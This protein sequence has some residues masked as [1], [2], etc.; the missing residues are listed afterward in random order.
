MTHSLLSVAVKSKILDRHLAKD[1]S[2]NQ[3][4][5]EIQREGKSEQLFSSFAEMK[6]PVSASELLPIYKRRLR[7]MSDSQL[8]NKISVLTLIKFCEDNP[9]ALIKTIT[10]T[11]ETAS[12]HIYFQVSDQPLTPIC[13]VV[14]K[15]IPKGIG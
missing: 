8:D 12:Y 10:I 11:S 15:P 7:M 4:L 13:V 14:G 3:L 9:D 6:S 5:K 2:L 1:Q